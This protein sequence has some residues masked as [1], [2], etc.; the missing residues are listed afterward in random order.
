MKIVKLKGGIG[1]QMFQ[2]A[3]AKDLEGITG[4]AVKLDY[5][6]YF[7]LETDNIRKTRIRKMR[8]S[9]PDAGY[10]DLKSACFFPRK[11]NSKSLLYKS[12]VFIEKSFN[13][14]YCFQNDS[15]YIPIS[16]I[17]HHSYFD[18]Y[19]Q[20]WK[21]L[22]YNADLLK[23]EF[24]PADKISDISRRT[25]EKI[26]RE[27]A[28]FIGARRGDY[29]DTA[30]ARKRFGS[31]GSGYYNYAMAYIAERVINPVFYIFSDDIEWVKEN[32]DFGSYSIR[33]REKADQVDDFEELMIMAACKH[34]VIINSTFHFWGAWLINNKNKIIA[35]PEQWFADGTPID[36]IPPGWVRIKNTEMQEVK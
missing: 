17:S 32:L 30:S 1:N 10:E 7:G 28:V 31:F 27:N 14:K 8:L 20:S 25:I 11:G 18:G 13:P 3:F 5:S 23:R 26:D 12:S 24:L 36:I 29:A 16:G 6:S 4:D 21:Y 34:A 22:G 15:R 35:A 2:Y 19:W 9:L 33:Y